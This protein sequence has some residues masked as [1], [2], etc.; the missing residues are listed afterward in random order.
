MGNADHLLGHESVK[1]EVLQRDLHMGLI[2]YGLLS[3]VNSISKD[4]DNA[5]SLAVIVGFL[6]ALLTLQRSRDSVASCFLEDAALLRTALDTLPE[7]SPQ[8]NA[9]AWEGIATKL[10]RDGGYDGILIA[11]N[12]VNTNG[13]IKDAV[14]AVRSGCGKDQTLVKTVGDLGEY[15]EKLAAGKVDTTAENKFFTSSAEKFVVSLVSLGEKGQELKLWG[16]LV[17]GSHRFA[18]V[19]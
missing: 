14:D 4:P 8:E 12:A 19:W 9:N 11:F 1:G 3:L 2:E 13:L 10:Q 6:N 17:N 7:T 15:L 5:T 18:Q 16:K